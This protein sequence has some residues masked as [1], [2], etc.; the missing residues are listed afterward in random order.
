[1]VFYNL[2][3]FLFLLMLLFFIS[4]YGYLLYILLYFCWFS[5]Y[6]YFFMISLI[7]GVVVKRVCEECLVELCG[8]CYDYEEKE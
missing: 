1:M 5:F 4:C 6:G 2:L 7:G 3:C 8:L